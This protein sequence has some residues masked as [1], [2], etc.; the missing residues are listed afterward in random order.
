MYRLLLEDLSVTNFVNE[1]VAMALLMVGLQQKSDIYELHYPDG[2]QLS[3]W[4]QHWC[5]EPAS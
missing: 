4:L 3:V 2:N 1:F 5:F